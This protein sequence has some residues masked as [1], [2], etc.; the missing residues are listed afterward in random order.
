MMVEYLLVGVIATSTVTP[1]TREQKYRQAA[2]INAAAADQAKADFEACNIELEAERRILPLSAP[3]AESQTPVILYG[4][5]GLGIGLA[6]G[7]I[8]TLAALGGS[9]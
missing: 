9:P 7:A 5:A 1:L 3:P 4:L 8:A 2:I 6:I